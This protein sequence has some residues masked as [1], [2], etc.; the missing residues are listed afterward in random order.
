MHG[1]LKESL[2][3][4]SCALMRWMEP[5]ADRQ[6]VRDERFLRSLPKRFSTVEVENRIVDALADGN[7]LDS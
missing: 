4:R 2:H 1:H 6:C 7:A 5:R 3:P